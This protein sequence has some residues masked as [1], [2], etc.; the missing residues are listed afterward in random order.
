VV[1]HARNHTRARDAIITLPGAEAVV[2][3]DL[4]GIFA[5]RDGANQ[6]NGLGVFDALIHN[7]GVYTLSRRGNTLDGI[8]ETFA[9]NTPAP[10]ILACLITRPQ[11]LVYL[12]SGLHRGG[13]PSLEDT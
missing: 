9:V 4:S 1:L 3:G 13:N 5:V 8:P 11:R 2:T 7:A 6:V 12:S 10:Y